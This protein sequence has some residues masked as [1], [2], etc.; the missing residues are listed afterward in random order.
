MPVLDTRSSGVRSFASSLKFGLAH[1][2]STDASATRVNEPAGRGRCLAWGP[3]IPWALQLDD[4]LKQY[5]V[6]AL[7]AR[8]PDIFVVEKVKAH[9]TEA[10]LE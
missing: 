1:A 6:D 4:D 10:Q 8:G 5:C 2:M 3:R 9:T 7:K